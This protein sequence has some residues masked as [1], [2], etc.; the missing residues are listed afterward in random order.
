MN[1]DS[2]LRSGSKKEVDLPNIIKKYTK[3]KVG[4][5]VGDQRLQERRTYADNIKLYGWNR[6]WGM[7]GIQQIR[8]QAFLYWADIHKFQTGNKL[9]CKKWV[10]GRLIPGNGTVNWE[11]NVGLIK[12]IISHITTCK[13]AV[14]TQQSHPHTKSWTENTPS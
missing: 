4:V 14:K 1:R 7:H 5:D 6:K 2:R 8:H 12:Q 10:P 11:F 3:G 13:Q 9:Q